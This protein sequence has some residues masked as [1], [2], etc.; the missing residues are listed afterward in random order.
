M[1]E[2][3]PLKW[4]LTSF[5]KW[6]KFLSAA[7]ALA[8]THTQAVLAQPSKFHSAT[9]CRTLSAVRNLTSSSVGLGVGVVGKIERSVD[10]KGLL[11]LFAC[12]PYSAC[13]RQ[14]SLLGVQRKGH[15]LVRPA[16]LQVD[17][18]PLLFD[19]TCIQNSHSS[20]AVDMADSTVD[21]KKVCIVGSGNW[22][23]EH[24][25]AFMCWM[26]F[27]SLF[28]FCLTLLWNLIWD[29]YTVSADSAWSAPQR[30]GYICA[31]SSLLLFKSRPN[32]YQACLL[33]ACGQLDYEWQ[34]SWQPEG[35]Y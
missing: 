21:K 17:Q 15:S 35:A 33:N 34:D 30:R 31:T 22:W 29:W 13:A 3:S 23:A 19:L 32:L 8:L 10:K 26:H 7:R 4:K 25:N 2:R 1:N 18:H 12:R 6:M 24:S 28:M 11:I 27:V 20:S 14:K 9:L 5:H 16:I